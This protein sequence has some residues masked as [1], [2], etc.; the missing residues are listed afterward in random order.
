[1]TIYPE[2]SFR[3]DFIIESGDK[4]LEGRALKQASGQ[5]IKYFLAA[6]TIPEEDLWVNLS[7]FES[8]RVV[9]ESLGFTELGKD[10]LSQDYILKQFLASL[11]YPE[12]QTGKEFWSRVYKKAHE[13]YGTTEIPIN[14]FNK[15]WVV[16]D[17]AVVYANGNSAY[18]VRGSLKVMLEED[19]LALQEN[20]EHKALGLG[21]LSQ[22][23][24]EK[25]SKV[26]SSVVKEVILPEIEKE[27]NQGENFATL[28]QMYHALILSVWFKQKLKEH[29]LNEIYADKEKIK[30]VDVN[31]KKVKEKIYRQYLEA[32]KQGVYNYIKTDFD[33]NI[34]QSIT[35]R[36]YAGGYS[37][38]N[39]NKKAVYVDELPPSLPYS[40]ARSKV[41]IRTDPIQAEAASPVTDQIRVS[42]EV[43]KYSSQLAADF[44]QMVDGWKDAQGRP[45]LAIWEQ[46]LNQAREAYK[47]DDISRAQLVQAEESVAR[48]L[49]QRIRKEIKPDFSY[50]FFDL[51]DVI[52]QRQTQCLGYT[53]LLYI[54]GNSLGLSVN[55][56]YVLE[57]AKGSLSPEDAHV[58]CL[59]A[60]ADGKSVM[61]DLALGMMSKPFDLEEEFKQVEDS[62]EL[63]DTNNH[64]KIHR[65]FQILSRDEFIALR[66]ARRASV[67]VESGQY[68]EAI[69]GYSEAIKLK[70]NYAVAYYN[71]GMTY[72]N[73]GHDAEAVSDYTK[74][75]GLNPKFVEAYRARATSYVILGQN[76]RAI[77]DC[78]TALGLNPEDATAY[79]IRGAAYVNSGQNEQ[80]I[81]DSTEAIRLN[82]NDAEAYFNRGEAYANTG[83]YAEAIA[84]YT[85]FI[86]RNPNYAEAYFNRGAAYA[87]LGKFKEAKNDLGKAVELDPT[88]QQKAEET[89][90][91]LSESGNE[92][93]SASSPIAVSEALDNFS[94]IPQGVANRRRL[95]SARL[96][97]EHYRERKR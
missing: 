67:Y 62:L 72:G 77:A 15:V 35:R 51:A 95:V 8:K 80:A 91:K 9:P 21:A 30:G 59:I 31:D 33:P 75:I 27:I 10:L 7:P 42:I 41:T 23:K 53:E 32:Y 60:R 24:A 5:L 88:Y 76:S 14:T 19:Y 85:E 43:L 92:T 22:K 18:V 93:G 73:L 64:L 34:H 46:R 13:L 94:L 1:V 82:P 96:N 20:I 79:S 36:Y 49:S 52:K 61:V 74:A 37:F 97:V 84:D 70:P 17:E 86:K 3:F 65:R 66:Y 39:I 6:I 38:R 29:I 2:D 71:R 47:N 28:R 58:A 81:S 69:S 50:T 12:S 78:T 87:S 25:V 44:L 4:H 26:A 57:L 16:P 83:R 90:G 68:A 89:L 55:P 40:R 56:I 63:K 54:L 45:V 11:M 48:E